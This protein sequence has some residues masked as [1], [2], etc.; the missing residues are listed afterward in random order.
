LPW[1]KQIRK[2]DMM[3]HAI[4]LAIKEAE[5]WG[6]QYEASLGKSKR[7]YPQNK[8]RQEIAGSMT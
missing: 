2:L 5:E 6:S 3:E 8:L 7:P 4:I 1:S